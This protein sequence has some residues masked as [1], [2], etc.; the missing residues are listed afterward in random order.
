MVALPSFAQYVAISRGKDEPMDQETVLHVT[1]P[2]KINIDAIKKAQATE[3]QVFECLEFFSLCYG[4]VSNA[5]DKSTEESRP[6]LEKPCKALFL[7]ANT[8]RKILLRIRNNEPATCKPGEITAL[9]DGFTAA[10]EA[11]EALP[12]WAF[13]QSGYQ[14]MRYGLKRNEKP[15]RKTKRRK[16]K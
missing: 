15:K 1:L 2:I 7:A 16:R 6:L 3:R 8:S 5:C 12:E 10:I 4:A 14:L 9:D 11:H 13:M